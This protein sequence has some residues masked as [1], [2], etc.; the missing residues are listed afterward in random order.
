MVDPKIQPSSEQAIDLLCHAA[1]RWRHP[2]WS[3]AFAG[4]RRRTGAIR[5]ATCGSN[6]GQS[7]ITVTVASSVSGT[8]SS[9]EILTLGSPSGDFAAGTGTSN[10]ASATLAEGATCTESI[11]FTPAKPGL[12][13]GAVVLVGTPSGGSGQSVLGTAYLSGTGVGGL[14]VLVAGN[15]QP[16][17]GQLGLYTSVGD[18]HPATQAELYLPSGIALDGAGNLYIADSLHNRIRMVCASA[19]SA[20]IQGTSCT[21]AGIISTI[22]GSGNPSYTGD[23]GP[24]AS[25][26]LNT[27]GDVAIDGAGNLYIADS[28]NN[29][30]RMI[31][32]ATGVI[33][34]IAGNN[35]GAVC[36]SSSDAVGD[37]CP[38]T[39][40]TLNQPQGVTL[41][42]NANLYIADTNN[43]RIREVSS[44]SGVISTIAGNGFA[45]G[46][47]TGG[48]NGDGIAA[49]SAKLNFPYA[50]A[51]D[52][53]GNMYIPDSANHRIREV[54]AVGGIIT[55]AST[56][57]T[58]AGTGNAAATPCTAIPPPVAANQADVWSPS[59]VAVDAA[60]N[61]YIAE[62]Q[63]A[64]I[65]KVSVTTGLI[66]TLA[67]NGCGDFY[68]GGQFQPV[69]LYGPVG[70]YLDGSGDLYVADTLDMVVR[71][72]QG[73]FA[74]LDYTA[75]IR[76][77][78][79]SATEDET[80]ENDGNAALDLTAIAHHQCGGRCHGPQLLH[81]RRFA[82]RQRR[83]H[84]W[85]C[86]RSGRHSD[87][88]GKSNRNAQH[89]RYRRCSAH[90]CRRQLAARH[91]AHW[92]RGACQFH[93]NDA[94]FQSR[95]L[96]LRAECHL[97]RH[98]GHRSRDR[99]PYRNRQHRRHL[100]W[101]YD[102]PGL[103]PCAQCVGRRHLLHFHARCRPALHRR[104]L[105]TATQCTSPA[106]RL[107]RSS[108]PFLKALRQA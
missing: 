14:G 62:T 45:N 12:R 60:G 70:L 104:H 55:P 20:T 35:G 49:T 52:A 18:G 40:A 7:G 5:L 61:V 29:V 50:V 75:P 86:L 33:T 15:L 105:R 54:M 90:S 10:C 26:T 77:G 66:S 73:N 23:G 32:A 30:I 2:G 27:P 88:P 59:G 9:V 94:G 19:T 76:Q 13:S 67:E 42:A 24:A 21:G 101:H 36:G 74:A 83:L 79:T 84:D 93:H 87:A 17:A 63:N 44:A 106:R 25:A 100:W 69:Q 108:K 72:I 102:P 91:R 65:R 47:G 4:G 53:S 51:F 89:R 6:D 99:K 43:H 31:A 64:A 107:R 85:R 71:E 57:S 92:D 8:V 28:G 103:G 46:N 80:V 97:H 38:A 58:F 68:A 82:C 16:V 48:Y 37:G 81:E 95:S 1:P 41:D 3:R 98:G 34:T 39:Q 56:I 22:A 96:R 78:S 11:D